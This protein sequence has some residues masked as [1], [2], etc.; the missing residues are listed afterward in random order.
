MYTGVCWVQQLVRSLRTP[1]ICIRANAGVQQ[2]VRSLRKIYI[3]IRVYA[4]CNNWLG[5]I[6]SYIYVNGCMLGATTG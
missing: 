5:V 4:G 2:L 3:C 6:G 1:Y